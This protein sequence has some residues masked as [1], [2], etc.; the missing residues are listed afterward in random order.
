MTVNQVPDH[1]RSDPVPGGGGGAVRPIIAVTSVLGLG[2]LVLHVGQQSAV[3]S[4]WQQAATDCTSAGEALATATSAV[5]KA[6]RSV[7]RASQETVAAWRQ[8]AS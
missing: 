4:A 6:G 1:S 5:S 2:M 8:F 7:V 3:Q